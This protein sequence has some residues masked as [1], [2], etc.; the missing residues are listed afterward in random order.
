MVGGWGSWWGSK[1]SG[2]G[3]GERASL[4][5]YGGEGVKDLGEGGS[6]PR[7]LL[8]LFRFANVKSIK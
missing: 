6:V 2:G 3:C 5:R 4:K 7:L 1:S 8:K